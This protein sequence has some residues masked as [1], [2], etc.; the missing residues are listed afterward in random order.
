MKKIS[1]LLLSVLLMISCSP[2]A[3]NEVSMV[4]QSST[5]M[6]LISRNEAFSIAE[7]ASRLHNDAIV[8]FFEYAD[9]N[10]IAEYNDKVQVILEDFMVKYVTEKLENSPE[11]K[12]LFYDKDCKI[13]DEALSSIQYNLYSIIA[14]GGDFIK[15][16]KLL[17]EYESY[18]LPAA[19]SEQ[20][21][22]IYQFICGVAIGTNMLWE[23]EWDYS[24]YPIGDIGFAASKS[25]DDSKTDEEKK[26]EEEK[27]KKEDQAKLKR[28][29]IAGAVNGAI[30]GGKWGSSAGIAG[31]AWGALIGA[32]A[33]AAICSAAEALAQKYIDNAV[34]IQ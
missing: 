28:A 14:D 19:K 17:H 32:S 3:N 7:Y 21:K 29:D 23:K 33:G 31:A 11:M 6:H 1:I 34:K 24:K 30:K 12:S 8:A 9:A 18:S 22:G 20:E 10:N 2:Q 15:I 16:D 4:E 13:N 26:E 5:P 27:K 25:S